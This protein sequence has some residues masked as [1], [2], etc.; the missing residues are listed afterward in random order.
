MKVSSIAIFTMMFIVRVGTMF[1]A[2]PPPWAYGFEGPP[3]V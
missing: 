3:Q 1:A 2:D